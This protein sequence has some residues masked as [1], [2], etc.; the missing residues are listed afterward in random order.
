[1]GR[2]DNSQST[3]R[4]TAFFIGTSQLLPHKT[5]IYF[6]SKHCPDRII[7]TSQW[8]NLKCIMYHISLYHISIYIVT[9]YHTR[10]RY[11]KAYC[12]VYIHIYIYIFLYSILHYSVLCRIIL[13]FS[14]S[15][16]IIS[17]YIHDC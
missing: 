6:G 10:S 8:D 3:R 4:S 12:C 5:P 9:S 16:S 1:M 17:Y 14:I 7:S 13:F 2:R 11:I 15:Y